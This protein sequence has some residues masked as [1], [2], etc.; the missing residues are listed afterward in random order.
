[1]T[2]AKSPMN[3]KQ[4]VYEKIILKDAVQSFKTDNNSKKY[5]LLIPNTQT[6][7]ITK[8]A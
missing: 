5:F 1:M 4:S 8:P 3:A 6:K 2:A 7:V